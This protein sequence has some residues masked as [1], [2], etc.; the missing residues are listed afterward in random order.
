MVFGSVKLY[1]MVFNGFS[2]AQPTIGLNG[3]IMVFGPTT[4][5]PNGFSIVFNGS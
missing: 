2:I 3:F 4:V 5:G 1:S